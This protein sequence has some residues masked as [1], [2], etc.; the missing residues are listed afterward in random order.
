MFDCVLIVCVRAQGIS[1]SSAMELDSA[2]VLALEQGHPLPHTKF[3]KSLFRQPSLAGTA[4]ACIYINTDVCVYMYPCVCVCV[5][6]CVHI[7]RGS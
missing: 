2:A 6:V 5:C 1:L 3:S 7:Q 4:Y